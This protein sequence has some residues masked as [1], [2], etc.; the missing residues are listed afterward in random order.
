MEITAIAPAQPPLA[1][2]LLVPAPRRGAMRWLMVGGMSLVGTLAGLASSTKPAAASCERDT[3]PACCDLASCTA[4]SHPANRPC[5]YTCPRG[6]H[7]KAWYCSSGGPIWGCG[8]CV[9]NSSSS[10]DTGPWPC[11]IWWLD[12]AC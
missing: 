4:C 12:G 1:T 7:A 8:E 6:Y 10:C 3:A 2:A 9:P 11:S 5:A